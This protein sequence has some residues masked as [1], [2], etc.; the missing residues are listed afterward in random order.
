MGADPSIVNQRGD[1]LSD[2][3][4]YKFTPSGIYGDLHIKNNLDP[5]KRAS[6]LMNWLTAGTKPKPVDP[7]V[8]FADAE[9]IAPVQ[10]RAGTGAGINGLFG[11]GNMI[12]EMQPLK[13]LT[14]LNTSP[15]QKG[16]PYSVPA[17]PK[18]VG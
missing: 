1:K 2:D 13:P 3:E 9:A 4:K 14:G 6:M 5:T 11:F 16:V 15:L 8:L 10:E 12:G 17:L 18:M 7:G